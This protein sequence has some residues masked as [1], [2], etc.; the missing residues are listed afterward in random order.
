MKKTLRNKLSDAIDSMSNY[1]H[2]SYEWNAD[3][4]KFINPVFDE[5]DTL[6]E[7]KTVEMSLNESGDIR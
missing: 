4:Y 3:T 7:K 1:C 5:V 6:E 2:N